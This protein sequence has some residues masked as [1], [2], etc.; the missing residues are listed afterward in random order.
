MMP[1]QAQLPV[2]EYDPQN[3]LPHALGRCEAL[4]EK[5]GVVTDGSNGGVQNLLLIMCAKVN[6]SFAWQRWL[7]LVPGQNASMDK[8]WVVFLNSYKVNA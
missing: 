6:E 5:R 8:A 2:H 4:T 1:G 3:V 7:A